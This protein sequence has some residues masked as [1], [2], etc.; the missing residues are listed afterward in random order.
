MTSITEIERRFYP[1][2]QKIL[3]CLKG[4]FYVENLI[5]FFNPYFQVSLVIKIYKKTFKTAS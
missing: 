4:L 1:K 2:I 5:K 3:K